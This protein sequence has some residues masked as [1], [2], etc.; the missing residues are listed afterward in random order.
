MASISIPLPTSEMSNYIPMV[1]QVLP[2][3]ACLRTGP[4]GNPYWAAMP[5]NKA[6]WAQVDALPRLTA[7]QTCHVPPSAWLHLQHVFGTHALRGVIA[8]PVFNIPKALP[9]IPKQERVTA[10]RVFTQRHW[11]QASHMVDNA[12]AIR[13]WE[14]MKDN[15]VGSKAD[16]QVSCMNAIFEFI[17]DAIGCLDATGVFVGEA[18]RL[19]EPE[20]S[21]SDM[22]GVEAASSV[23][24]FSGATENDNLRK[25][26]LYGLHQGLSRLQE[27]VFT[28]T[29]VMNGLKLAPGYNPGRCECGLAPC[30]HHVDA[31]LRVMALSELA[32]ALNRTLQGF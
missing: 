13:T 2:Y 22:V 14:N 21:L 18:F 11:Q 7:Q 24:R 10:C 8:E 29:G 3:V 4:R 20:Y 31:G 12:E 16:A 1:R 9:D 6:D 25:Q 19:K 28:L 32:T 23:P 5:I 17:G 26:M 15:P 27:D 30:R